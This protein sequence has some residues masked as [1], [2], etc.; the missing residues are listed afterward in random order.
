M[1]ISRGIPKEAIPRLDRVPTV[2]EATEASRNGAIKSTISSKPE[3]HGKSC[4]IMLVEDTKPY[5]IGS[6][7]EHGRVLASLS[8]P[9][10]GVHVVY[11]SKK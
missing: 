2:R 9:K 6:D 5:A 1:I 3:F 4:N 10:H 11:F 8:Y 7:T